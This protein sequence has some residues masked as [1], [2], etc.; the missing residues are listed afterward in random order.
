MILRLSTA[1]ENLFLGRHSL[2]RIPGT[3]R[4]QRARGFPIQGARNLRALSILRPRARKMRAVPGAR[5]Q[6]IT[7]VFSKETQRHR[8]SHWSIAKSLNHEI[9]TLRRASLP[10]SKTQADNGIG[11]LGHFRL[12]N[13]GRRHG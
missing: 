8:E 1:N 10:K 11:N 5:C 12:G 3:A 2:S 9:R 6:W 13:Y 7:L 4:F